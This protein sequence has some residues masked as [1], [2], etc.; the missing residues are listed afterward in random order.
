V[1][2][3]CSFP[4]VSSVTMCDY[5]YS[6]MLSAN[7]RLGSVICGDAIMYS[8]FSDDVLTTSLFID[9]YISRA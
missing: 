9:I 3:I 6:S 8:N 2:L 7:E 5:E 4:F 1:V